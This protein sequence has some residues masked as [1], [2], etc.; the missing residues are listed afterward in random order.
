VTNG[1]V[2][3]PKLSEDLASPKPRKVTKRENL[4]AVIKDSDKTDGSERDLVHGEGGTMNLPTKPALTGKTIR[5][6]G[7]VRRN[8]H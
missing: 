4:E 6:V 5:A 7:V 2:M 3:K 1:E 8:Q